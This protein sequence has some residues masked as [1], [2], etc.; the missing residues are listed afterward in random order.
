[1]SAASNENAA[2]QR[3]KNVCDCRRRF[4]GGILSACGAENAAQKVQTM[5]SSACGAQ[6]A[7]PK[8]A[9]NVFDCGRRFA[10]VF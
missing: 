4:E 6:N 2:P 7:T 8:R 9:N 5:F 3:A 1:L 10:A